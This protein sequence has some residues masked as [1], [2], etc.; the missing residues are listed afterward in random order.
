[1]P[2][3]DV[4]VADDAAAG[5][6][7]VSDRLGRY[8]A[9]ELDALDDIVVAIHGSHF[10]HRVW[11]AVRRIPPGTVTSYGEL[12]ARLGYA[13]G[14]MARGIGTANATNAVALI[15]PCHRVIGKD[16][17]LRGYAWGLERKRWLLEHE[18][19]RHADRAVVAAHAAAATL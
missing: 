19:S 8:F 13:D 18:R 5:A 6:A 4:G 3:R 15:I 7:D 9:G 2:P 1:L 10:Q 11:A 17:G 12:A 16:G 14:R